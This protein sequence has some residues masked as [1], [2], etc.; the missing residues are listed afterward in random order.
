MINIGI[1]GSG[2]VLKWHLLGIGQ[3]ADVCVKAIASRNE[4]TG[5]AAAKE[6]GAAYYKTSHEMFAAEELDGIINLMPNHLHYESCLDAIDAGIGHILCEKPLGIDTERTKTLVEKV[7]ASGAQLMAG[8]M[9]RFNPGFRKAKEALDRLGRIQFA[10]FTTVE[11]GAAGK[12]SHRD[13]SSPWKTDPALSGGGNLTH[14][15]SHDIDL[16]RYLFGDIEA[17]ACRLRRDAEGLPEYYAN[18]R[19]FM[20]NGVEACL[21]I[22]RVNVPD[23]GPDWELFKGGWNEILEVIGDDGYIRIANPNW[24]GDGAIK[25]TSWFKG[26][27]GPGVAYFDSSQQWANE[28]AVFAKGVADGRLGE[29]ATSAEDALK[30]DLAVRAMRISDE[31]GGE[32][33]KIRSDT[34]SE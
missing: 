11:T 21:R 15:G 34:I 3:N 19:L 1:L 20:E 28:I 12:V 7:K 25:V 23:L 18:G 14:V 13:S 4:A 24:E 16:L 32:I 8:Y 5:G 22:G 29:A 33:V 17:V 2:A 27:P 30:V 10:S 6:L 31:R 9:K 26:E